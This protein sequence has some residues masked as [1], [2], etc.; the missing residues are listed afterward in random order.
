MIPCPS[1]DLTGCIPVSEG[2][3]RGLI[4]VHATTQET[5]ATAAR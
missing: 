4:Q 2:L 3:G 5:I 1:L